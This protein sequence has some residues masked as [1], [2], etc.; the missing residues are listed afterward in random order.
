[1]GAVRVAVCAAVL[2]LGTGCVGLGTYTEV[3]TERDAL[4]ERVRLLEASTE[5]LSNERV[6]LLEGIEDLRVERTVLSRGVETLTVQSEELSKNLSARE[7]E[8]AVQNTE[9][10]R[11][12]GTYD[13]LVTDLES[14]LAAGQIQIQQLKEGLQVNV[15]NNILFASG[16]AKLSAEGKAVLVRVAKELAELPH[17]IDVDGHTDDV[18]I[19]GSLTKRYPTNWELAGARAASVV[20]LFAEQ[21]VNGE[22][23]AAISHGEFNPVSSNETD[24]GRQLNRRIEIRLRPRDDAIERSEPAGEEAAAAV[25]PTE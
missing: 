2:A 12:R 20:R 23:L 15:S 6:E 1:M 4:A 16:S 7:A 22:R 8:L 25:T 21:G 13:S 3:T 19:R 5:S 24:E 11:L 14:E 18:S 9:V 10:A 17:E